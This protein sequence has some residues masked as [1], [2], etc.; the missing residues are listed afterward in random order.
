[1]PKASNLPQLLV[2]ATGWGSKL[3]FEVWSCC[4]SYG[5]APFF[6]YFIR[7][8]TG[9]CPQGRDL[10][11]GAICRV[12]YNI[13]TKEKAREIFP[14]SLWLS[15]WNLL[16][17]LTSEDLGFRGEDLRSCDPRGALYSYYI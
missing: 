13:Q 6:P 12:F 15:R 16:L 3:C 10:S 11:K 2:G 7:K 5:T 4:P 14:R 9:F 8:K 17:H 1:M